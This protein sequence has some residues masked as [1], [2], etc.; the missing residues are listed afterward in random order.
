[1]S[2]ASNVGS[3]APAAGAVPSSLGQGTPAFTA[4]KTTELPQIQNDDLG[5]EGR[6]TITQGKYTELT[7][8]EV[9]DLVDRPWDGFGCLR[10]YGK[11]LKACSALDMEV[12]ESESLPPLPEVSVK[13]KAASSSTTIVTEP[14]SFPRWYRCRQACCRTLAN[15]NICVVQCCL[16]WNHPDRCACYRCA[17]NRQPPQ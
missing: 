13:E 3:A 2:R 16:T 17:R 6:A 8:Q 9:Q 5:E 7:V 4:F 1:M 11:T 14:H 15:G 10:N 12:K